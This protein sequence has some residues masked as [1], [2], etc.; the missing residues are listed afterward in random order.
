MPKTQDHDEEFADALYHL[1]TNASSLVTAP[2]SVAE[3]CALVNTDRHQL[4]RTC[5]ATLAATPMTC[6]DFIRAQYMLTSLLKNPTVKLIRLRQDLGLT[7]EDGF[8][9]FC[10]RAFSMLPH[11]VK[12][13]PEQAAHA[14]EIRFASLIN[15][16]HQIKE[17]KLNKVRVDVSTK[18]R[19]TKPTYKTDTKSCWKKES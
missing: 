12:A 15:T 7:S 3:L 13:N 10:L 17:N 4:W 18:N 16:L 2:Q 8:R 5:E 6:L 11:N 19:H 9:Q 1:I 14:V